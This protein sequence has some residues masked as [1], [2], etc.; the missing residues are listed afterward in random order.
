VSI[1]TPLPRDE[2]GNVLPAAYEAYVEAMNAEQALISPG[3]PDRFEATV[4]VGPYGEDTA[5]L[6]SLQL[7][8]HENFYSKFKVGGQ[9]SAKKPLVRTFESPRAGHVYDLEGPDADAVC[10]PPA[11]RVS[12]HEMAVEMAEVYA[13]SLLRDVPFSK[14]EDGSGKSAGGFKASDARLLMRPKTLRKWS[15]SPTPAPARRRKIGAAKRA[16]S[17][18]VSKRKTRRIFSVGPK[19]VQSSGRI[20]RNS[21]WLETGPTPKTA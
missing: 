12:S 4:P 8:A 13:M 18:R 19:P 9:G 17:P 16:A 11:P 2:Y 10:M 20:S 14:I 3:G 1:Q 21:C 7:G 5:K 15:G 6:G